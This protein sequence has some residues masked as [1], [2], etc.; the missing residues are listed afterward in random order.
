MKTITAAL[1]SISFALFTQA[2]TPTHGLLPSK[3]HTYVYAFE[4]PGVSSETDS[5]ALIERFLGNRKISDVYKSDDNT[6]YYVSGAD[7]NETFEHDLNTQNFAF[8]KRRRPHGENEAPQLPEREKA[9]RLAEEFLDKNG[10][11][12]RNMDELKMVH[13]GGLRS[14]NVV[15]GK[16]TGPIVD[17]MI[18]VTYGRRIDSL[19]VI[20]PGS[21]IILKV[22]DKGEVVGLV[23]R[24]RELGTREAVKEEEVISLQQAEELAKRQIRTE[25]GEGASYKI[26]GV[27][28]AYY[29]NN[30]KILQPVYVFE[31]SINLQSKDERVKPFNY[32]CVIPMLRHSP[33][34]LTL[35]AM[36]PQAK[37]RIRTVEKE[38][39]VIE[40][41]N[42]KAVTND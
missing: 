40:K 17:E 14:S 12:P 15:D 27:G 6:V 37:R 34:P 5:Q 20:G 30:G 9:V 23:R 38:D 7:V 10:L 19:P 18:T 22:G 4:S 1:V 2:C 32:L 21:K 24:W 25:Y 39:N 42:E 26:L 13:L 35:T 3:D 29:D 8:N 33:E 28:K 11:L 36:D 31:T 16:K 41:M